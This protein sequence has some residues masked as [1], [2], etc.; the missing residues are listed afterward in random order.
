MKN[1]TATHLL[2]AALQIVLGS[3]VKQ[4]GSLVT[5]DYLRF[6]FTHHMPL[7]PE[8]IIRIED[9]VNHKI[10]ENITLSITNSTYKAAVEAGVIAFFGEKY[11]PDNVRVVQIP[12]I[13]AELCGGT[14]VRATGDIGSFKITENIALSAGNRRIVA[15]TGPK[16]LELF[17]QDFS[18]IKKLSQ[19][20]K[21]PGE[22]LVKTVEIQKNDLQE[23]LRAI[24]Q[25]KKSSL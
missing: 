21:V 18:L 22:Q 20:L 2:Q 17:Q 6:D 24:K 16:A 10:M 12:G 25:L 15:L 23:S 5:P 8:E 3:H 1:H 9:I 4:S 11:N 13:S 14:H 7:T 19:E